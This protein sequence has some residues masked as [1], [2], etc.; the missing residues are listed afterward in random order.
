MT[1]QDDW[2]VFRDP[3]YFDMWC[4]RERGERRL[5]RSAELIWNFQR[6]RDRTSNRIKSNIFLASMAHN[7]TSHAESAP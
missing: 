1:N 5:W 4:V 2:E 6:R 7:K 3:A